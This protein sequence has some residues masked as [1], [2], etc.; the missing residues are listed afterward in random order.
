[1]FPENVGEEFSGYNVPVLGGLLWELIF[2]KEMFRRGNMKG[3]I[4]LS[5]GN[6]WGNFFRGLIFH[7]KIYGQMS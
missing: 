1:M 7:G 5:V 3:E 6:F 4:G 2:T